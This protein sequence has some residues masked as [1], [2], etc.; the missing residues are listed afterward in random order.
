MNFKFFGI[1]IERKTDVLAF[2][3]FVISIGSLTAQFV[4]LIRGPEIVLDGPKLVT[5][6]SATASDNRDYLRL[7]ATFTYLNKGSPGYDDILKSENVTVV[8][9]GVA[10]KLSAKNYIET[11]SAN[12]NMVREFKNDAIPVALKSGAVTSHETEFIPYPGQNKSSDLDH[13]EINQFVKTLQRSS[14][15]TVQF[16][17]E[18]YEGQVINKSCTLKPKKVAYYLR[19]TDKTVNNKSRGWS[20]SVCTYGS[21]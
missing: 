20:T 9:D 10:I 4:N 5:L 15:L 16:N 3:A 17:I 18:T 11:Y 14:S 19:D 21:G 13:A 6:Y 8:M 2:A 12:K 1:V 7:V